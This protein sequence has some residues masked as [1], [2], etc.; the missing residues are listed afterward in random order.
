MK[1]ICSSIPLNTQ[2]LISLLTSLV[3]AVSLEANVHETHVKE[4]KDSSTSHSKEKECRECDFVITAKDIGCDG[5]VLG[6]SGYYCLSEDV[7]NPNCKIPPIRI[8]ASNITLDLRDRTRSQESKNVLPDI[9]VDPGI[10]HFAIKNGT[11]RVQVLDQD[12]LS[13][14]LS[15]PK[16]LTALLIA[17]TLASMYQISRHYHWKQDQSSQR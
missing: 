5:V 9:V 12:L 15:I 16:S 8:S 11:V 7:F 4:S 17:L 10:T 3:C 1:N 6:K 14:I 2:L 13:S